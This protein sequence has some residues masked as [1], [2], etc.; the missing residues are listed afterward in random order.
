MTLPLRAHLP[1]L[2]LGLA[3]ATMAGVVVG[4]E[5]AVHACGLVAGARALAGLALLRAEAGL[6]TTATMQ[7]VGLHVDTR[8]TTHD[9]GIAALA[10]TLATGTY[11]G[12]GLIAT[13]TV[14][15]IGARRHAGI[16]A[17]RLALLA[18]QRARAIHAHALAQARM[19]T[20]TTMLGRGRRVYADLIADLIGWRTIEGASPLDAKLAVAAGCAARATV[21]EARH[22]I[23]AFTST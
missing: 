1:G 22:R 13:T 7:R 15:G 3:V 21:L 8:V 5:A 14:V 12:T 9:E 11:V 18:V 4:V 16:T 6:I 23:D 2:A 10:D 20:F 17:D 19:T